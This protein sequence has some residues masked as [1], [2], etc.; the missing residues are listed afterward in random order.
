MNAIILC[1][2]LSTRL[3]E[4]TKEIPKVLLKIGDKTVF[5]WQIEKIKKM[6]IDKVVLAAGHLAEVLKKEI[7]D[8]YN[9]V[10][11]IYAI[12]D[13]KL[14]TGGAIKNALNYVPEKDKAS[15]ILNGDILT[16]VDFNDLKKHLK[17][18]K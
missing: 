13:K 10:K 7:G 11:V 14:G 4:I 2:G 17:K 16:T 5:E 1:G 6:G 8:E 18:N 12:E 3:G 15:I 9:A